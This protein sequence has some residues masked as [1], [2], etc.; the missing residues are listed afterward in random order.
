VSGALAGIVAW[1]GWLSVSPAL[2][3]PTLGPA[4]MLNRVFVPREDPGSWLG[5]ALLS[6][7]LA[8][9]ALLYFAAAYRGRLRPSIASGL[10]YGAICWLITGAIVMPILGLA[11]PSAA[12]TAP[13]ALTPP[14]PMHGSFMMLHLGVGAPIAALVAWLIFGAVLGATSGQPPRDRSVRELVASWRERASDP[15]T[16][17]R[18]ALGAISIVVL[19][20]VGVIVL[21]LNSAAAD[22]SVAST[23]T[24]AT[25]PAQSL[26][27]GVDFFSIIEL[28]QAPGATLGP[29]VHP[30]A[31]LAYSLKGVAT[32]S[33]S[34]G[35]SIRVGPG[36]V[37]LIGTQAAH[38]HVNTDDRLLSAELAI[39][40]IALAAV[41]CLIWLRPAWR[42]GRLLPIALVL[43]LGAGALGTFNPWSNDWLFLSV[44][45]VASR[46]A[47]MPL[48]TSSRIYESPDLGALPGSYVQ[49]LEEI[50]VVPG[51]AEAADIGSSGAA[52]LLVLDGHID[53]Q[54]AGG[55]SIELDARRATLVQPG[56]STRVTT[57][58]D[59]PAH[60]LKFALTP[61][62][63]G[64]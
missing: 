3:F 33:F 2:G 31:G 34:D 51:A 54:S 57:A 63:A 10:V 61:V 44:R 48:P 37:G 53:V 28:T 17:L 47:A 64:T 43:L 4:A 25:E 55:S 21:R 1:V 49:T 62:P 45:P 35:R 42:D 29:H 23:R 46:G 11:A 58:G 19:V 7:G 26:P 59:R 56:S 41:V 20:A 5:W 36:E 39:L 14:D 12:A 24:L 38:S 8:S 9:A 27:K 13:A 60:V 15:R 52:V 40:I 30:Y 32:V 18:P 22:A 6:I 50:T 16:L